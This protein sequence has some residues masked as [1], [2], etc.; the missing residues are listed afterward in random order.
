M[1]IF[2][3]NESSIIVDFNP[4]IQRGGVLAKLADPE[5]FSQVSLGEKG[6]YI[7][8]PGEIEFCADALWF[9][10]HPKENKFQKLEGNLLS[11]QT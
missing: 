3:A 11:E 2:Y 6:R 9:D 10:S 4:I 1:R 5:F 7:Q 8:W